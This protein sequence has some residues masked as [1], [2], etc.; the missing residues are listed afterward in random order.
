MKNTTA[1][2]NRSGKITV[3]FA[4]FG[5]VTSVFHSQTVVEPSM[6]KAWHE[7]N[8]SIVWCRSKKATNQIG[9]RGGLARDGFIYNIELARPVDDPQLN[10]ECVEAYATAPPL[11][12]QTEWNGK[13]IPILKYFVPEDK[14]FHEASEIIAFIQ[15]NP[16]LEGKAVIIHRIPPCILKRYPGVFDEKEIFAAS[17]CIAITINPEAAKD[18]LDK[19]PDKIVDYYAQWVAFFADHKEATRA[20]ILDKADSL[21]VL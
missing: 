3:V 18:R 16:A 4:V 20:E 21:S 6:V 5:A 12:Q 14:P 17:N 13:L 2:R 10:A 1:P 19:Y 15:K 11:S 8:N 7:F 9:L